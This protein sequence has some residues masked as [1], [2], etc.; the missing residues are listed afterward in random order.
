MSNICYPI[1]RGRRLR[2]TRLDGCGNP[3]LG[4]DSTVVTK[5]YISVALTANIE[6]GEEI[7]ITNANGDVC[8]LDT[9]CPKL[10]NYSVEITFCDVNPA[11][12]NLMSGQP[13][14]TNGG[15]TVGFRMNSD[16]NACD[17]G[18][19]LELWT[20]VATEACAPGAGQS[21]GYILLP[22]LQGGVLGDFTVENAGINFVLTGAVT[23][24]G[25]GWGVGPYDVV[26]NPGSNEVQTILITGT[27]TGGDFTL[28][29]DGET[30]APIAFNA[31]GAA[32]KAAL[33]ALPNIQVGD[34][35]PGGGPLPG[36]QVS[37]N[38]GGSFAGIDVPQ[39]TADD[40]G[41]TGGTSPT[42]TVGTQSESSTAPGPLL[43]PIAVADHLHLERT[44]VAPPEPDCDPDPLGTEATGATAGIPGTYTPANSYGPY[45][46]AE[47]QDQALTA[48]PLSAWTTGQYIAL[49]DGS[50]AHWNGTAWV[51]GVA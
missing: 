33:E 45:D 28:T 16:V 20:G 27:P 44:T 43:E 3:V 41:L 34:I 23:K 51:A 30:T 6:E 2:A 42:V 32:V 25:S 15:D 21:Y 14:V 17:S 31:N 11:L 38:F 13:L 48:S 29:F 46:L 24:K 7:S 39:M 50:S 36:T 8:V 18:F 9:P 10:Q 19:A 22:F 4:P 26:M 47:L 1:L 35:T 12:F 40:S 5:G 49:R 37:V